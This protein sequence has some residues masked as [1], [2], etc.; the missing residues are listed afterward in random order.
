[1]LQLIDH[2]DRVVFDRDSALP[3]RADQQIVRPE[4]KFPRPFPRHEVMRRTQ[5][6]PIQLRLLHEHLFNKERG[7]NAT[8]P[9]LRKVGLIHIAHA[10][11]H[12]KRSRAAHRQQ[13][14]H[15]SCLHRRDDGLRRGPLQLH[16]LR[17]AQIFRRRI[18]VNHRILPA[19]MRGEC[20]H[21]VDVRLYGIDLRRARQFLHAAS[22]RAYLVPALHR[23][24]KNLRTDKTCSAYD[25]N[26]HN[27]LSDS[28][29]RC[30]R[31]RI[32]SET[33]IDRRQPL[34][35]KQ[36]IRQW[37]AMKQF[38][39]QRGQ[40]LRDLR[41]RSVEMRRSLSPTDSP[42]AATDSNDR[43][44]AAGPRPVFR[45]PFAAR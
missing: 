5:V 24:R 35:L 38:S 43:T 28:L 7:L 32:H 26:V 22:D 23:L 14:A 1:M 16:L 21:V 42:I 8:L 37:I 30:F 10:G 39:P 3:V 17:H 34:D 11:R 44:P 9:C 6:S 33:C 25:C 13:P 19:K 36:R 27:S 20:V 12:V 45:K 4:P 2:R 41:F 29:I 15:V 40:L 31:N 18:G